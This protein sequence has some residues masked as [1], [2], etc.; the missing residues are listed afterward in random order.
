VQ[1][2]IHAP[3]AEVEAR[4]PLIVNEDGRRDGVQAVFPMRQSWLTDSTCNNRRLAAKPISRR[5]GR[6]RRA[7]PISK[8]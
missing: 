8:S 5:A 2:R 6:L 3:V 1:E 4:G 7:R